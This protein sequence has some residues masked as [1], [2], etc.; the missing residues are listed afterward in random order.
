LRISPCSSRLGL[1]AEPLVVV[2]DDVVQNLDVADGDTRVDG[3]NGDTMT[4]GAAVTL[5]DNV[6][7]FVD[8]KAVVLVVDGTILDGQV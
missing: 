7:A 6:G 3:A 2:G 5:E 1:D 4:A 8:G